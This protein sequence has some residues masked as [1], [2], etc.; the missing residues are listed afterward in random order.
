VGEHTVL[1]VGSADIANQ[2]KP[3]HLSCGLIV[4]G[5]GAE[6]PSRFKIGKNSILYPKLKAADYQTNEIP[7]GETIR[8]RH[9]EM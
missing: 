8:P 1:G 4:V 5:K 6:I 9:I 3:G 2:E 7:P